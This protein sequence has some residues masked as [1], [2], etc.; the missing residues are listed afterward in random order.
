MKL[1]RLVEKILYKEFCKGKKCKECKF[2][3]NSFHCELEKIINKLKN[4]IRSIDMKRI[5]KINDNEYISKEVEHTTSLT[6][7]IIELIF[8]L[9]ILAIITKFVNIWI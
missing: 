9:I 5:T 1:S 4:M 2:D 7:S 8:Y 6:G 3:N